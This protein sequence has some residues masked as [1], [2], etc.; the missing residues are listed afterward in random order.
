MTSLREVDAPSQLLSIQR[1]EIDSMVRV[2]YLLAQTDHRYRQQLIAAS[3]NGARWKRKNGSGHVTDRAMVDLAQNLHGWTR[4]VYKFG[5]GF[6]HLS[7]LH[8]HRSRDGFLAL[9]ASERDDVI[10]HLRS[11]HG[12]PSCDTPTFVELVPFLPSFFEKIAG[13]L[14]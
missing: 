2:I 3:V 4:S 7:K 8:D 13:N 1:Q 9:D 10:R 11:Y 12:G 5:C 6:I 14:E